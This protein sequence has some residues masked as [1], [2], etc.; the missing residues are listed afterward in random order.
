MLDKIENA[1][2][3]IQ[4][5]SALVTRQDIVDDGTNIRND[6]REN[7]FNPNYRVYSTKAL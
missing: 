1:K 3:D 4:N 2:I 6:Y 7:A 5:P